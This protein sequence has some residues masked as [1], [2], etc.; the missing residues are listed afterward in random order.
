MP[1]MYVNPK[2]R[3]PVVSICSPVHNEEDNL[4]ELARRIGAAMDT[5]AIGSGRTQARPHKIDT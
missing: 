2:I 1:L 4:R 5:A 3:N